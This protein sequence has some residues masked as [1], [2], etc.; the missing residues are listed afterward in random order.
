MSAEKIVPS[1]KKE[2]QV[3]VAKPAAKTAAPIGS[4]GKIFKAAV[5]NTQRLVEA[6]ARDIGDHRMAESKEDRSGGFLKRTLRRIWKHNLAQE[7]KRQ[8]E[9]TTARSEIMNSKN[10]YAGEGA[11]M[12]AHNEAM[13]AIIERFTSEYEHETLRKEERESK[14]TNAVLDAE[15]KKLIKEYAG[16]SGMSK[17]K[18]E[19]KKNA[20]VKKY[21]ASFNEKDMHADNLF[22]IASEVRDAVEHG[23]KLEALDFEVNVVLGHARESL[24]TEKEKH[25]FDKIMNVMQKNGLGV[26]T[27]NLFA[28]GAVSA[29]YSAGKF[30]TVGLGKKVARLVGF[31][32]GSAAAGGIEAAKEHARVTRD[33]AQHARERAKGMVFDEED[34]ERRKEMEKN[35]YETKQSSDLTASLEGYLRKIES[36]GFSK[37]DAES[38]MAALADVEAR[39][40]L[41]D[42]RKIDLVT[43][44][45]FASVERERTNLDLAR[46]RM[47]VAFRTGVENKTIQYAESS[48][49]NKILED[50][51]NEQVG[52][53]LGGK[54]GSEGIEKRDEIF[55]SLRRRRAF[56]AFVNGTF[57]AATF[58]AVLT[59]VGNEARALITSHADQ[60]D[61][62]VEGAMKKVHEL[63]PTAT[64]FEALR[65]I[66]AHADPEIPFGKGHEF[67]LGG[68]HLRLPDGVDVTPRGNGVFD[69]MHG[70]DVIA[71]NVHLNLD[72]RGNLNPDSIRELNAHGIYTD[73]SPETTKVSETVHM[74]AKDWVEKNLKG[75]HHVSREWMGNDTAMRPDPNNPGHLLGADLNELRTQWAGVHGTGIAENGHYQ[76]TIQHMTNDG[77][78]QD[79]ASVAAH[80]EMVAGH[81]KVALSVTKDSQHY[82]IEVPISKEGVIDIDPN[83]PEGKMLFENVNGHAVYNGAYLEIEKPEGVTPDGRELITVLGT[84]EGLNHPHEFIDQVEKTRT[85]INIK[86]NIK[87][88]WEVLPVYPLPIA[89]R[90]PLERGKAGPAPEVVKPYVPREN[91]PVEPVKVVEGKYFAE[92]VLVN[93]DSDFVYGFIGIKAVDLGTRVEVATQK[94]GKPTVLVFEADPEKKDKFMDQIEFMKKRYPN[95]DFK[96]VPLP[97]DT[98]DLEDKTLNDYMHERFKSILEASG[99]NDIKNKLENDNLSRKFKELPKTDEKR[100]YELRL[101]ELKDRL[102]S[103]QDAGYMY[104]DKNGNEMSLAEV[105]A[106]KAEIEQVNAEYEKTLAGAKTL[107]KKEVKTPSAETK[108]KVETTPKEK[109]E[110]VTSSADMLE[111]SAVPFDKDTD[112]MYSLMTSSA[113]MLRTQVEARLKEAVGKHY[114]HPA[115]FVFEKDTESRAELIAEIRKLR[116]EYPL[117]HIQYVPINEGITEGFTS[118]GIE[119]SEETYMKELGQQI[120]AAANVKSEGN[121]VEKIG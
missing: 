8:N 104:I 39:I 75:L 24:K 94:Y 68:S 44:S 19:A 112:Y 83:S 31:A 53:L 14:K 108:T 76:M 9:I 63:A 45:S 36:G 43:Y 59:T 96:Y 41:G 4:S 102:N 109:R 77:S 18:F 79:G 97:Q 26:L 115:I 117:A 100:F 15:M 107:T 2:E 1:A 64:Q 84:H 32:A 29:A 106:L 54:N 70:K 13:N 49:F 56:R 12:S 25:T 7:Y 91:T 62:F 87:Q 93:K 51:V 116:A 113:D 73:A 42:Q 3:E 95:I 105:E 103:L 99:I 92:D 6:Q 28:L 37:E 65:R 118:D 88:D 10:L 114:S 21:D 48:N 27:T 85:I 111:D 78:F 69:V 89:T 50:K 110:A 74:E 82:V 67:I 16:D 98:K 58:G 34:M 81:L 52:E 17:A 33:R 35:M 86:F 119:G 47:K 30:V 22:E 66:L 46:A 61:N 121:F 71:H 23:Q 80:D 40:F 11:D 101:N 120:R 60:I 72:A 38:A 90:Q 5:V 55:R 20:L 57:M